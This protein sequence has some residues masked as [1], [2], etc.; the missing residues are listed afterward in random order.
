MEHDNHSPDAV[1]K[2]LELLSK[3]WMLLLFHAFIFGDE[4]RFNEIKKQLPGMG[5]KM[6]SQRLSELEALGFVQR[7][8][9]E[10][11]PVVI[12]YTA[13]EK[14]LDILPLFEALHQWGQKWEF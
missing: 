1:I 9:R 6:L 13:T 7:T 3:K 10:E 2:L 4:L 12:I 5:S 14:I 11:K 8:I